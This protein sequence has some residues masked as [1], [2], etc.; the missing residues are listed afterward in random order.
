[1]RL[2][3]RTGGACTLERPPALQARRGGG[4][5]ST[6]LT[7][8]TPEYSTFARV[9]WPRSGHFVDQRVRVFASGLERGERGAALHC[10][11]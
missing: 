11:D 7:S 3:P 4:L 9:F 6:F 5:T 8:D 10:V 1:M 2:M